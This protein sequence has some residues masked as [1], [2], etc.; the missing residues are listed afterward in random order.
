MKFIS[1]GR[2]EIVGN[3][4]DHNHGK[5]LVA[6]IELSLKAEAH[7]TGDNVIV[8]DSRGFPPVRVDLAS[9]AKV[10]AEVGSPQGLVRGVADGF[11]KRGLHIGGF[12]AA[13]VGDIPVGAGVS[14][15]AAFELLAAQILNEFY[16]GGAADR[17]TLAKIAQYAENVYMEKPSGLLDQM[18]IAL[19]GATYI[20]F[21][22]I[23]KPR[24]ESVAPQILS[25]YKIVVVN[26]GGSHADM[27]A[28]YAAIKAEMQAAAKYF[29]K[30]YL[31]DVPP[32]A[33]YGAVSALQRA[34]GGR[35]ILRAAHFYEENAR[36]EKAFKA[37]KAGKLSAFF[38]AV[39]E[40]GISSYA[41]LQNCYAPEDAVQRI[42]L[43]LYLA[44]RVLKKGAYRVHGGGFAGTILAFVHAS[45][46]GAFTE[47]FA[48][49][50]GREN[51]MVTGIRALGTSK[52]E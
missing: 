34:V 46:F 21:Q 16:N 31:A 17:V 14:S 7:P 51:I 24:I 47:T 12:H 33:F 20:D 52:I 15:S 35:A 49:V 40:S 50:F 19:G 38:S 41:L 10:P 3:H 39:R 42:P 11:T 8:I 1:P 29:G 5:V 4:T 48:P 45:E 18:G 27:T 44:G 9:T 30:D 28:H 43:A 37:L 22:D 13:A 36:V 32:R 23:H 6:A 25:E 2:I 26:T